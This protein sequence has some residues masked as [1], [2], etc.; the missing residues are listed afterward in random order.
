MMKTKYFLEVNR[1]CE[2]SSVEEGE[3]ESCAV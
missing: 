1:M 3:C 2:L